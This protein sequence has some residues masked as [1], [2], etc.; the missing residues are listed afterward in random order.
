[1]VTAS[2]L[3]TVMKKSEPVMWTMALNPRTWTGVWMGG[4]GVTAES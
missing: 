4:V 2:F 1:M 3:L